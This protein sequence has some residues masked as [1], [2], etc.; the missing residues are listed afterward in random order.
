MDILTR[1]RSLGEKLAD[2]PETWRWR[3]SA[4][5]SVRVELIAGR[6]ASWTLERGSP[7][8]PS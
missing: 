4:G 5:D 7:Q 1:T 3:D 6:L 2:E 8:D